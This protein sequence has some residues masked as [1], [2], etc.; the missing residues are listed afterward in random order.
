MSLSWTSMLVVGAGAGYATRAILALLGS[1]R[2]A[3]PAVPALQSRAR[4]LRGLFEDT[5]ALAARPWPAVLTNDALCGLAHRLECSESQALGLLVLG[6]FTLCA[7]WAAGPPAALAGL[8][9]A[10][11]ILTARRNHRSLARRR[12]WEGE[13]HDLLRFLLLQVAA[14]RSFHDALEEASR[15]DLEGLALEI[16]AGIER[17]RLGSCFEAAIASTAD[18]LDDPSAR[19][20]FQY[21]SVAVGS[22]VP[23][24]PVLE[25]EVHRLREARRRRLH[26]GLKRLDTHATIYRLLIMVAIFLGPVGA[27]GVSLVSSLMHLGIGPPQ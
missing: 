26:D 20:F 8:G 3:D 5:G 12:S 27:L 22:G 2:P 23:L 18:S 4:G 25:A 13:V 15:Q 6:G 1:W 21:L 17:R 9:L 24:V 10:W 11:A 14:G 7:W 16:A 19:V